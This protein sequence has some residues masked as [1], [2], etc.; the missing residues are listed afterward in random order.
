MF[1]LKD[2][3]ARVRRL[4]E[5]ARGLSSEVD[6]VKD[7]E[8]SVL[9]PSE[10]RQY[11]SGIYDVIVGAEAARVVMAKAVRRVEKSPSSAEP[12][13]DDA[14]SRF[15]DCVHGAAQGDDQG[16]LR[17]QAEPAVAA[18]GWFGPETSPERLPL[19]EVLFLQLHRQPLAQ[20]VGTAGVS[21]AGSRQTGQSS[22]NRQLRH[23]QR[24][25][26][27]MPSNQR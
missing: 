7:A 11:V 27:P 26:R 15:S 6:L 14:A 19:I 22:K 5:F 1:T 9:L 25:K 18:D 20:G 3:K 24:P 10:R 17:D 4:E 13:T 12:P 21:Q 8:Q 2:M 16:E 23:G